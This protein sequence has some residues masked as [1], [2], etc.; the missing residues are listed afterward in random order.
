MWWTPGINNDKNIY[1]LFSITGRTLL[2]TFAANRQICL[3]ETIIKNK[4]FGGISAIQSLQKVTA[5][6][7]WEIEQT[8][9]C[10]GKDI[11]CVDQGLPATCQIPFAASR[12]VKTPE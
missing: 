12:A 2:I 1:K 9:I 7:D 10:W 3:L 4:A 5:E 8:I 6:N 11:Q